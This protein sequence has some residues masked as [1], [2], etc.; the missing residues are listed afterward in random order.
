[1]ES[2]EIRLPYMEELKSKPK[3]FV[4]KNIDNVKRTDLSEQFDRNEC[5]GSIMVVCD[6][7]GC[8]VKVNQSYV[9]TRDEKGVFI[10]IPSWY[11]YILPIIKLSKDDFNNI[12]TNI[13]EFGMVELG[14][15]HLL[16]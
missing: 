11:E 2:L 6:N 9:N 14:F 8:K 10:S 15:F 4:A 7:P 1:M 12:S 3:S 16:K 13:D 5:G